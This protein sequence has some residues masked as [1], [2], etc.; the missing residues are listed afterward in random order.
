MVT[1]TIP[2][3]WIAALVSILNP[4]CATTYMSKGIWI[5]IGVGLVNW[6]FQSII[7]A[8]SSVSPEIGTFTNLCFY[9][10]VAYLAY[11]AAEKQG[12]GNIQPKWTFYVW[13]VISIIINALFIIGSVS[14]PAYDPSISP[15]P[16]VPTMP[17][18]A[19]LPTP[20]TSMMPVVGTFCYYGDTMNSCNEFSAGGI[21]AGVLM[22]NDGNKLTYYGEWIVK[23]PNDI[24]VMYTYDVNSPDYQYQTEFFCVD[25]SCDQIYETGYPSIIYTKA[26]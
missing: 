5:F 20:V 21:F 7:K 3:K 11:N 2:K 25:T 8:L 9:G 19:V 23:S 24:L 10:G 17:P 14:A 15:I 4:G 18:L 6:M 13:L 22:A 26:T 16:T 1:I 12:E